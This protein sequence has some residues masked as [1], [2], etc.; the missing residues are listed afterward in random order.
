MES[1]SRTTAENSEQIRYRADLDGA[2]IAICAAIALILAT[3]AFFRNL[4]G[5]AAFAVGSVTAAILLFGFRRREIILDPAADLL[6]EKIE[7]L[8][9]GRTKKETLSEYKNI[10]VCVVADDDAAQGSEY[11]SVYDVELRA[12]GKPPILL[13]SRNDKLSV[14]QE[15]EFLSG[16]LKKS[17]GWHSR[18][19]GD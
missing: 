15:V 2:R 8:V 18:T 19:Y 17:V 7:F 3:V 4:E 6:Q 14:E 5:A 16:R 1:M 13:F 9:T 11:S 12:D 10:S